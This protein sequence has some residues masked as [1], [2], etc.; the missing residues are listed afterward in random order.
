MVGDMIRGSSSAVRHP[1]PW[2]APWTRPG[3]TATTRARAE[4]HAATDP[5]PGSTGAQEYMPAG[6]DDA[7]QLG[8]GLVAPVHHVAQWSRQ[9][10]ALSS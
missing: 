3:A 2:P 7:K 4:P 10:S 9:N 8:E 5:A 6:A 1:E